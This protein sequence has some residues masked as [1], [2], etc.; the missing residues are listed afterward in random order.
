MRPQPGRGNIR[1]KIS[2]MPRTQSE[3]A[4]VLNL[5]KLTIEKKR[6]HQELQNLEIRRQQI[7]DRLTQLD[8]QVAHLDATIETLRSVADRA[9]ATAQLPEA[10]CITAPASASAASNAFNTF[11][12]EY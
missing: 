12:L 2:T 5:Y 6:L 8:Q 11:T 7:G 4:A 9:A 10:G 1:P 3:A